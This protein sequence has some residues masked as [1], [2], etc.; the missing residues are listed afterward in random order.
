MSGTGS[1][2]SRF[3]PRHRPKG[4]VTPFHLERLYGLLGREHDVN[5][6]ARTLRTFVQGERAPAVGAMH[7]TCS[8]SGPKY[9]SLMARSAGEG[10]S[11]TRMMS[12]VCQMGR[13]PPNNSSSR[14]RAASSNE[15]TMDMPS[16]VRA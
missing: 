8:N 3:H 6:V 9:S 4:G 13:S 5:E 15:S 1:P 12:L 2:T 11:N 16:S 10:S 14:P 7:V